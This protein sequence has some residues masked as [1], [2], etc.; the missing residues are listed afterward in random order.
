[1]SLLKI[2][3]ISKR[4]N[5]SSQVAHVLNGLDMTFQKGGLHAILG[6]SGCGKTTLLMLC[7]ALIHPDEGT[8]TVD[9]ENLLA[10]GPEK[11]SL[12]RSQLIGFVFQQ[13]HLLPYLTTEQNIMVPK[14]ARPLPEMA[15]YTQ[16]LIHRLGLD[17]RKDHTPDQLSAG[18][19]QRVA[20]ARALL[21][22]PKIILADEP[23]GNLDEENAR[24]FL[25]LMRE[26]ADKGGLVLIAT[27][28]REVADFCDKQYRLDQGKL[29]PYA[30]NM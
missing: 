23:T 10:M 4:Y 28:N 22:R 6:P 7:G 29:F 11:C 21:G 16:E 30:T 3:N 9:G 15:E 26:F 14:L 17:H 27:H 20:L 18:E 25:L 8:I 19:Q 1:M 12:M 13:F 2:E 24:D 5:S